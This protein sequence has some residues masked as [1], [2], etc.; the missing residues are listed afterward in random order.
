MTLRL[1]APILFAE[2]CR[3]TPYSTWQQHIPIAMWITGLARPNLLVELGTHY[4]D[5]YCAFCQ[6]VETLGLDTR[7]FAVDTWEGDPHAGEI[8]EDVLENLHAHHDP[9]YGG[10]SSLLRSTFDEAVDRSMTARSTSCTLTGTTRMKPSGTTSRLGCRRSAHK[11]W[12]CSTIS[13]SVE[14]TSECGGCGRMS[15]PV[16]NSRVLS[17]LWLGRGRRWR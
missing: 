17:W 12:C 1:D 16:P 10:F 4:G 8:Q 3:L 14:E 13:S 15:G 2:P 5:S 7:C 6:A 9:L 11:A